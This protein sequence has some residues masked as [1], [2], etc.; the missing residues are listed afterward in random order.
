MYLTLP[1]PVRTF[2]HEHDDLPAFHAAY[3]L[4]TL[5]AAA[6]LSAGVFAALMLAHMMFDL[7]KYRQKEKLSWAATVRATLRESLPDITLLALCLTFAVY[8]HHSI[9]LIAGLSG[10]L[11]SE[12]SVMRALGIWLPKFGMGRRLIDVLFHGHP[13]FLG[14][15]KHRSPFTLLEWTC[16]GGLGFFVFLLL[17]APAL[18]LMPIGKEIEIVTDHL[19]VW[20]I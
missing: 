3:L 8:L 5:L 11:H 2:V 12:V 9:Q 13:Q 6:L 14:H 4:L 15:G 16:A 1:L 18:I 7:F 10:L 20:R 19:S 17:V